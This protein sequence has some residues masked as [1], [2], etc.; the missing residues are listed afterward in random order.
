MTCALR[1]LCPFCAAK[2]AERDR[3][4]LD[5][6]VAEWGKRGGKVALVTLTVSHTRQDALKPL[7]RTLVDAYGDMTANRSYKRLKRSYG[8]KYA[9]RVTEP[10]WG[11]AYGWHP[12][13]HMLWFLSDYAD[14]RQWRMPCMHAGLRPS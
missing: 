1:W 4:A 10:N 9:I 7:L 14:R 8:L 3:L 13:F 6:I 11:N 12:H 2:L 5:A